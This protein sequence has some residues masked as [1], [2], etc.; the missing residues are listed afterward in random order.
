MMCSSCGSGKLNEF[1]GEVAIHFPGLKGLSKPVVWV[2]P[3][4]W[5]CLDCGNAGL[6]VP[7]SE[8]RVLV[9]NSDDTTV[10]AASSPSSSD[11]N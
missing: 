9:E 11:V 6:S 1:T 3:E 4:I 2:F 5:V 7:E 8:L 10:P